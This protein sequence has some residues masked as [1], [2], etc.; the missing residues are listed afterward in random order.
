[1]EGQFRYPKSIYLD[2]IEK[3]VY[4]GDQYS[5]QLFAPNGQCLQRL[6]DNKA[7]K[8]MNQFCNVHGICKINEQLYV[9]DVNNKRIQIFRRND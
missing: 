5:V 4:I 2:D 6:G 9:T 7:G 8:K 3:I 1:M